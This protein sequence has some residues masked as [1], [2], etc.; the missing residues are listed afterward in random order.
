MSSTRIRVWKLYP[1]GSETGAFI[2]RTTE[3]L[4]EAVLEVGSRDDAFAGE[5]FIIEAA[6]MR[7]D[8]Y[9]TLPE[10]DGF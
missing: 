3:E 4:Q 8:D 9:K 10:F 1:E 2:V 6:W 5:K 7:L